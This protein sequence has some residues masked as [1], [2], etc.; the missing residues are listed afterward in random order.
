VRLQGKVALITGA[1]VG[2]GRATAILFA[3]EGAKVGINS[4]T[5]DHGEETLRRVRE[6]GGEGIY[7]Q[8]D[9][10]RA[11][12]AERAV[13][14]TVRAFGKL[15][16][17]F[18]NAGIVIP[19]RIDNTSEEDW[20]RTMAVNLKG[21]FLASKYAVR[22]MQR[23]GGGV[24]IHNASVVA[25]KGVKDRAP[26]TASKGG[27]WALTKAMAADYIGE[28]IRVNCICPGTTYTPSLQQRIDSS[29][30]PEAALANF[31]SRQPMGRL[32]KEEEI[33][34]GVLYLAS[35][36]GAFITGATRLIDGGMSI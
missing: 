3:K 14:E 12:D 20:D 28:K 4:L 16:I 23:N 2:I 18:N 36:E 32:G 22:Q 15:D 30:D 17:L 10:S 35:D 1:G 21:V 29:P 25:L 34:A 26:Y 8:G 31:I 6:A 5:P 24:I 33:A 7:I 19:G 11:A 27:V 13:A 9:I